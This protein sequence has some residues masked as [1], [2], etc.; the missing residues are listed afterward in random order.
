MAVNRS[1]LGEHVKVSVQ[2]TVHRVFGLE[3]KRKLARVCCQLVYT[4]E[5]SM[6][7]SNS[8]PSNSF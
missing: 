2:C 1:D 8:M 4:V 3:Q 7:W 5:H 6:G